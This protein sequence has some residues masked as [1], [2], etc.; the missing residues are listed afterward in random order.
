MQNHKTIELLPIFNLILSGRIGQREINSFV[1]YCYRLAVGSAKHHLQKNPNIYYNSEIKATDL[2]V[3]AVADLFSSGNESPYAQ[4]ISSYNNWQP[5]IKT[6]NEAAFFVN[7]LV[8]RKVHQ[9]Y[10]T[11]LTYYDPFYT[12]ILHAVDYLIKKENLLKDFYLGNCFICEEKIPNIHKSFVD[13]NSFENLPTTLFVDR[14]TMLRN[15]MLYIEQETEFFPAIPLHPLIQRIK[16]VDLEPYLSKDNEEDNFAFS[17]D[18]V[19]KLALYKT[20]AKLEQSYVAKGKVP[21]EISEVFKRSFV[22]MGVDLK[23]GGL[24]PNLY[25]YIEQVSSELKKEEFQ[26]KYHNIFE[27]LTK[28][29]KQS[30]AEE[31]KQKI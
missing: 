9:Q 28:L 2:A 23:N 25:F 7:A 1:E 15:V 26:T 20:I 11:A 5:E 27:Y 22:E 21:N 17:A 3:D 31:L 10:Q 19:I 24:K 30:I 13:E 29:F 12:K 14:K 6:E 18:E 16:H 4:L 8:V